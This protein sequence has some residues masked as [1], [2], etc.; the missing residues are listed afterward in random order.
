MSETG[1]SYIGGNSRPLPHVADFS[2]GVSCVERDGIKRGTEEYDGRDANGKNG[3]ERR[4][5]DHE[6]IFSHNAGNL[7]AQ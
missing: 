5:R 6:T 3:G 2:T 1:R 4:R 7:K